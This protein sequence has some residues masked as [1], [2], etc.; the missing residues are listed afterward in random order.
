M[1]VHQICKSETPPLGR[2]Q[3]EDT[4][5]GVVLGVK[6]IETKNLFPNNEC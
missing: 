3:T 2:R 1:I 5:L 6:Y 4:I